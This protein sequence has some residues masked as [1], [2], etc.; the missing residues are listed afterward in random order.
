MN[1]KKRH[2]MEQMNMI[3]KIISEG[4]DRG[5]FKKIKN[6]D[7]GILAFLFA[8]TFRGIAMPLC[9]QTFPD[10]SQRSDEIVEMMVEGI[11]K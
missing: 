1:I 7:I 4:V 8:A 6:E 2:E 9:T 3:K 5:E 10:L 11:A